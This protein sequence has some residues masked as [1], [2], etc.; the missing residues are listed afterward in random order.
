MLVRPPAHQGG[1][2]GGSLPTQQ[3]I[4]MW[5]GGVAGRRHA[6]ESI[7]AGGQGCAARAPSRQRQSEPATSLEVEVGRLD[8]VLATDPHGR[9]AA[10]VNQVAH[11]AWREV[12]DF[13]DTRH[14]GIPGKSCS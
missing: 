1:S 6:W 13:T 10:R 11:G 3:W 7:P 2:F 14:I 5:S 12:K 4:R 8:V 9:H